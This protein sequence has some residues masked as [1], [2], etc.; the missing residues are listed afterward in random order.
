[1]MRQSAGGKPVR[2]AAGAPP[3]GISLG[4]LLKIE[5]RQQGRSCPVQITY[6]KAIWSGLS[7]AVGEIKDRDLS[8]GLPLDIRCVSLEEQPVDLKAELY[9]VR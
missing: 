7:W 6:D 8:P 4:N 2:T 1:M 3:N 9:L 5:A